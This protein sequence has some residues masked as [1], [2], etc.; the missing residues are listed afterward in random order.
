MQS[1]CERKYKCTVSLWMNVQSCWVKKTKICRHV[2]KENMNVQSRCEWMCSHVEWRKYECAVTLWR[3]SHVVNDEE[4]WMCRH[5]VNVQSCCECAVML[6]YCGCWGDMQ[7]RCERKYEFAVTLWMNLQW[8]WVKEIWMYRHVMNVKSCCEWWGNMNMQSCCECW[9]NMN[10]Q[11]CCH[12]N[13]WWGNMQAH[14]ERKYECAVTL[15]MCR[16]V[17]NEC[18]VILSEGNMNVQKCYECEWMMRKYECAVMLWNSSGTTHDCILWMWILFHNMTA[19]YECEYKHYRVVWP[20]THAMHSQHDSALLILT[21]HSQHDCTLW[22]WILFHI[23][24]VNSLLRYESELSFSLWMWI[25][26]HI[27]NAKSLSQL[28]CTLWMCSQLKRLYS[29]KEPY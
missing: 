11:S 26:F 17:V 1:C 29:A 13:E 28:D 27:M 18:A 15:W 4:I 9:G 2:V 23:M 14:C 21:A 3:C 5:V 24:N 6:S 7:A 25:L 20:R 10:V 12:V 8:Y 19:H 22:M 16:Q